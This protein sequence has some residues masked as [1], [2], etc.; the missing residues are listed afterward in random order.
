M[1]SNANETRA[2][3][4]GLT[5][6]EAQARLSQFGPNEPAAAT[7]H[8]S[9]LSDLVHAFANPLVLIL[10]MAATASAFL[11]DKVDAGIIGAMV[12][13]SICQREGTLRLTRVKE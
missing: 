1:A 11:G 3:M 9:F 7:K 12:L 8:Y 2:A 10:V 4:T 6:E 5:A 13:L